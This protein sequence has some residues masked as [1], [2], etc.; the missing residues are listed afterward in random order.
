[1]PTAER[2]GTLVLMIFMIGDDSCHAAGGID[3]CNSQ[4]Q[5]IDSRLPTQ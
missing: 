2:R 1:M 4:L 5:T 3:T